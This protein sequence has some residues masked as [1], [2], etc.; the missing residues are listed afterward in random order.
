MSS[1]GN[2]AHQAVA[3]LL[4][5]ITARAR[6]SQVRRKSAKRPREYGKKVSCVGILA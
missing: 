3:G 6:V 1:T 4:I 5:A 2:K